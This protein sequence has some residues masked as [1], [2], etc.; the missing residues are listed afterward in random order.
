MTNLRR[1]PNDLEKYVAL[2]ALHDRNET[3]FFRARRATTS[4]K[5][6]R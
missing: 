5:S 2:N 4:M 6:S 1:L 3:L